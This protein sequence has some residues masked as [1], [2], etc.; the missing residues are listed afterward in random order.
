MRT[1]FWEDD[2]V[3]MID[4]R[5]L[6]GEFVIAEFGTV[7]EV[8]RSITEMYV[9]GAP[10]IGGTGGF[11]MA[12]AAQI[13]TASDRETLLAELRAAKETLDA[14][15]PTAVNL[16]W[17]TKRLLDVAENSGDVES[18]RVRPARRSPNSGR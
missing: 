16:S 2:K 5:L 15:R 14:S 9:R 13:S 1:V 12:L 6:P 7:A 17:A 8:A 4:Q 18:I 11:G 10:A 3:K